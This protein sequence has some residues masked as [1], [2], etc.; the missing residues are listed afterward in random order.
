MTTLRRGGQWMQH[1][2]HHEYA[3]TDLRCPYERR[4]RCNDALRSKKP[5]ASIGRRLDMVHVWKSPRLWIEMR[6][7]HKAITRSTQREEAVRNH[8]DI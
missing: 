3:M 8:Q 1:V 6:L 7:Y 2:H 5:T 4:R